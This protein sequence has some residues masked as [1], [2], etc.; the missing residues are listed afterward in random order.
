M[1]AQVDAEIL[2]KVRQNFARKKDAIL[3]HKKP[4]TPWALTYLLE[5]DDS[6]SAVPAEL[7]LYKALKASAPNRIAI[8]DADVQVYCNDIIIYILNFTRVLLYF[9]GRICQSNQVRRNLFQGRSR[10]SWP[11]QPFCYGAQGIGKR[12][13]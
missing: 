4:W 8:Q 12:H 11:T 10:V 9:A 13:R 6:K 2:D 5:I 3:A 1:N 7:I